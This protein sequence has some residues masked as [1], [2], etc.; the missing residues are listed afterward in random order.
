MKPTKV[1]DFDNTLYRGESSVDFALF[2]IRSQPRIILWLP[3]IFLN[4]LKY[5]LCMVK[6][7]N[8]ESQIDRFLQS[9]LPDPDALRHLVRQFWKQHIHKLDTGI[10][11]HITPDDVIITAGPSFLLQPIQKHLR[12][13]H[14]ICSEVDLANKK[15]MYLNFSDRKAKRYRETHGNAPIEAFYTDSYNDRALMDIAKKVYLVRKGNIRRIR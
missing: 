10:I 4:L 6:K 5:K 8:M 14:L 13:S 2:L 7:E 12:T 15:V 3:K 11:R 9:C 1:F